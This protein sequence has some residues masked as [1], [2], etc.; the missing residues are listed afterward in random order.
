M[1]GDVDSAIMHSGV[2]RSACERYTHTRVPLAH[3]C[4]WM[5]IDSVGQGQTP[6]SAHLANDAGIKGPN[7]QIQ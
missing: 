3:P 1:Q 5:M 2:G 7:R 6:L 4:T